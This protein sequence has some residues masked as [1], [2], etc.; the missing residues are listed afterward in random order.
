MN[1]RT[2]LA[3]A[4]VA[5]TVTVTGA[6]AADAAVAHPTRPGGTTGVHAAARTTLVVT[7]GHTAVRLDPT[8]A[9]ALTKAGYRIRL[10]SEARARKGGAVAFPVTG[11]VLDAKTAAGFISHSGGL[12]LVHAGKRLTVRDFRVSTT[13]KGLSAYADQANARLR[14]FNLGLAHAAVS[15]SHHRLQI[16]GVG[17]RLSKGAAKT[18]NSYFGGS[19]FSAGIKLGTARVNAGVETVR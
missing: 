16:I 5:G 9:A 12:T 18:L 1:L 14:L 7:G 13:R 4:A 17:L 10:A 11:G 2:R 8:T 15:L 3:V 6:V 19:L